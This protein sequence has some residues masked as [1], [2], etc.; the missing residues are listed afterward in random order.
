MPGTCGTAAGGSRNLNF[1]SELG[2]HEPLRALH[3]V[4]GEF[5]KGVTPRNE[6]TRIAYYHAIGQFLDWC[7][8]SICT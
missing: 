8:L 2:D 3:Y 4:G 7:Q 5:K 6:N 1:C